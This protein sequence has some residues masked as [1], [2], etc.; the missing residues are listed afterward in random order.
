[1]KDNR[2]PNILINSQLMTEREMLDNHIS[3]TGTN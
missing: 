2:I 3:D 1:M